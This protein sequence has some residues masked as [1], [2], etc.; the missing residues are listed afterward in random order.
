M[1]RA[2]AKKAAKPRSPAPA[3]T[4]RRSRPAGA[5]A[6]A[7]EA[8]T[9]G[10]VKPGRWREPP[11]PA[12]DVEEFRKV[13]VSRRSVRKFT[14]RPIPPAVLQDCLD[15]A[16]LAPNSSNLQPWGLVVV[17][18]PALKA[19]LA[20]ACLGQSA[21]RTAA[22]LIVVTARTG[23]FLENARE[24]LRRWPLPSPPPKLWSDYYRKL[25]P[26]MY[27][28][29]PL[30]AL[31]LIKRNALRLA[32]VLGPIMRPPSSQAELRLWATKSAAL[33]A[34]NLMLALRAHGYDS[35][36]MEGFDEPRV[37]RL[38]R[39]P[40]DASVVMVIGAGERAAD[41]VYYPQMRLPRER[42]IQV[43]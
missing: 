28:Q 14:A 38:L 27:G 42:F 15:L 26:L 31:G 12:I 25:V 20:E 32:A 11:P 37:Q 33:A 6:P 3:K 22:E 18:T 43:L 40:R 24:S 5:T 41:G 29:G 39:L 30:G 4:A 21:A 13:V 35:C 17:Q 36:P 34:E 19:R 1:A 23:T 2:P 16:L 9:A 8:S 7:R 10:M